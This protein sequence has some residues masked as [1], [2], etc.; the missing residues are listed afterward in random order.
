M[1]G[2]HK[3]SVDK[4]NSDCC[5]EAIANAESKSMHEREGERERSNK[6]SHLRHS[7]KTKIPKHRRK[8]NTETANK[9]N[10]WEKFHSLHTQ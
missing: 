4:E 3:H 8:G 2:Q 6:I 10:N 1:R 5:L 9:V 7:L